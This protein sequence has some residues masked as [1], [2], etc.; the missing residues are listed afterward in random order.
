MIFVSVSA[1]I[2]LSLTPAE[3]AQA[4][5]GFLVCTATPTRP[6]SNRVA[7]L[8]LSQGDGARVAALTD[9]YQAWLRSDASVAQVIEAAGIDPR[10]VR[11]QAKVECVWAK[12][13]TAAEAIAV[14]LGNGLR[15][16]NVKVLPSN[17]SPK[18][19]PATER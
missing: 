15:A 8:N 10:L 16:D 17:W 2:L 4:T 5:E 1:A 9:E 18:V 14:R 13:Q 6:G 7:L 11:A 12:E 3:P 19:V